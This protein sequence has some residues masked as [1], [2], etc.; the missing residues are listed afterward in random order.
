MVRP[1]VLREPIFSPTLVLTDTRK[2]V[3]N[4]FEIEELLKSPL[5]KQVVDGVV[6][7]PRYVPLAEQRK[8]PQDFGWLDD[9]VPD[10]YVFPEEDSEDPM[11]ESPL[12]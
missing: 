11:G 8:H 5:Y 2:S 12:G 6:K 9:A 1:L 3:R 7:Q 4:P 10:D